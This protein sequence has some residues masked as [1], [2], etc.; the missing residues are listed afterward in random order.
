MVSCGSDQT[1][2]PNSKASN[3]DYEQKR[4]CRPTE[5]PKVRS[6]APPTHVHTVSAV[7]PIKIYI[8]QTNLGIY[9]ILCQ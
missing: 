5:S 4:A 1:L 9:D 8:S 3:D 6:W 2:G 7:Y